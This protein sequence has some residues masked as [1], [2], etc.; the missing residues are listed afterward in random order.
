MAEHDDLI[1]DA[2]RRTGL[3]DFGD[4]SFRKDSFAWSGACGT[5][6]SSTR[7]RWRC[8]ARRRSPRPAPPDRGLVPPAPGDGG[9]ADRVAT[10]RPGSAAHRFHRAVVPPGRRSRDPIVAAVGVRGTGATAVDRRG[11]RSAHRGRQDAGRAAGDVLAAQRRVGAVDRDRPDGVSGADGARLQVADL[12]GVCVHPVVLEVVPVRR[13]PHP[14]VPVRATRAATAAVGYTG[15][16]VAAEVPDAHV[17]PRPPR[18]VLS[19]RSVRDD[20]P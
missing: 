3:D 20:P 4:E 2:R 12:P 10:H 8:G 1:D 6:R 13:R 17:V 16:T 7:A 14:D 15:P 11:T 19:G 9:R 18:P 5:R